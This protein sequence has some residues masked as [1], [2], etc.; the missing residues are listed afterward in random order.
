MNNDIIIIPTRNMLQLN[1]NIIHL[2]LHPSFFSS[3]EECVV[4][5]TAF[6]HHYTDIQYRETYN[7]VENTM[8]M[9]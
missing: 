2:S 8:R 6:Y 9:S 1:T 3:V 4:N 5:K 7:C